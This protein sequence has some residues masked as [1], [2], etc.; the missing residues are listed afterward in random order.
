[1]LEKWGSQVTLK[2]GLGDAAP[3][4]TFKARLSGF[5]ADDADFQQGM[6]K[7]IFLAVD[8][9]GFPLPIKEK[10]TDAIW[11]EGRKMTVQMVDDFTRRV[12]GE[13]IAYEL[14]VKG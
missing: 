2:R 10:S 12:A 8:A 1:M 7:V 14:W 13:L 6:T 3:A 4:A 9:A 11:L 5:K